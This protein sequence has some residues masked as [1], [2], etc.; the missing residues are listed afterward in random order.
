MPGIANVLDSQARVSWLSQFGTNQTD[1]A[2]STFIDL[3]RNIYVTGYTN[4]TLPGQMALGGGDVFIRKYRPDG[5]VLWEKQFGTPNADYSAFVTT[6]LD[7]NV[8]VAGTTEG[9]FPEQRNMGLDDAFIQKYSSA[10]VLLWTRQFGTVGKDG[11][12][13]IAS[14]NNQDIYVAGY[15]TAAFPGE[16]NLGYSDVFIRKY[17]SDGTPLW[18]KQF[19]TGSFDSATGLSTDAANN[20]YV[21]GDV[22]GRL[23]GQVYLGYG[24]V[25]IRRYKPDGTELWTRQFGTSGVDHAGAVTADV[26]GDVY[27]AGGVIG[28]LP[29]QTHMGRE[30]AF[31]QK[32][33]DSGNLIRT[34]QFGTSGY[35]RIESITADEWNYIY[36]VGSAEG[37][38]P[39]QTSV[40]GYDVFAQ[41]YRPSGIEVWTS[42]FGTAADDTINSVAVNIFNGSLYAVGSTYG[43]LPGQAAS[44]HWDA[45]IYKWVP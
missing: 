12:K 4:G 1:F 30:D 43:A 16:T 15:T 9:T 3:N 27:I 18:T 14:D 22:E 34:K 23:P 21:V 8:Y 2:H 6:D 36:V 35:D 25:F 41:Q 40:G 39:G 17:K 24:D 13:A 33:T 38:L 42:Q 10:G 45:F 11:I 20:L 31:I 37:A 5:A 7:G 32:Y 26:S 44:G 29:G 28:A 19:G